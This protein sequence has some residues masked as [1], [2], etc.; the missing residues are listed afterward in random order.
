MVVPYTVTRVTTQ[1]D[2][3]TEETIERRAVF[4]PETLDVKGRAGSKLLHRSIYDVAVYSGE[5]TFAGHFAAPKLA[6]VVAASHRCAGATPCWRSRSAMCRGS[7]P[8]SP[9]P[10]A[11]T[12]WRSIRASGSRNLERERHPRQARQ[13]TS[14]VPA[15]ASAPP[16][17]PFDFRFEL[18]L[19]GSSELSFAPVARETAVE[20]HVRLAASEFRRRLSADRAQL[21]AGRLHA[22]AG[23]CRTS[24][25][26]CRRPCAA[27][28]RARAHPAV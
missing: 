22:R 12:R 5:L 26:A 9:R 16:L 15:A 2:K 21:A 20:L 23:R 10:S 28:R 17:A 3:R 27:R 1:G 8:P 7:S 24:R 19:N 11:P 6:D 13:R 4:L 18:T 14:L 25:A